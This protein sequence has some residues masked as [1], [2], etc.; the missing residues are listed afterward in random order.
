MD[1]LLEKH[2]IDP[3]AALI[4]PKSVPPNPNLDDPE[5]QAKVGLAALNANRKVE[6]LCREFAVDERYIRKCRDTIS[7]NAVRLFQSSE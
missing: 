7:E 4:L 5:F 1:R 3:E 2:G 6:R